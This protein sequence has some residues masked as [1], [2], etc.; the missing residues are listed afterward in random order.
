MLSPCALLLALHASDMRTD[1]QAREAA[2][3]ALEALTPD[4]I[5]AVGLAADYT[6]EC[7]E[8]VRWFDR[9]NAA[10]QH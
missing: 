1:K 5:V 2:D 3:E 4:C 8:C 9:T 10:P 7:L 6:A